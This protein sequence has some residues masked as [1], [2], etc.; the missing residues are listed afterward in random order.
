MDVLLNLDVGKSAGPDGIPASFWKRT[1]R[2]FAAPLTA[3]FNQSLSDGVFPSAWKTAHVTVIHK[4]GLRNKIDNYRQVSLLSCVSK[5]MDKLMCLR[6]MTDFKG[7]ISD[8]QHGFMTEKST[9]TKLDKGN[10]WSR[11]LRKVKPY[12][13]S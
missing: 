9:T 11:W 7:I 10:W 4:S 2:C 1:A 6:P 8:R 13:N 3:L 12:L 5:M